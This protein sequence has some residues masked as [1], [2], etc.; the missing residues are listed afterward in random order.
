MNN[1]VSGVPVAADCMGGT[2]IAW[3]GRSGTRAACDTSDSP[4]VNIFT[5]SHLRHNTY[6]ARPKNDGLAGGSLVAHLGSGGGPTLL[7]EAA[8]G[9]GDGGGGCVLADAEADDASACWLEVAS[10]AGCVLADAEADDASACWLE[11][12]SGAGCVTIS[13]S[14]FACCN[15]WSNVCPVCQWPVQSAWID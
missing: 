1:L 7:D 5:Y 3:G 6:I 14:R 10:G 12:A 11:V 4:V 2:N 8:V 15:L 13:S 9:K